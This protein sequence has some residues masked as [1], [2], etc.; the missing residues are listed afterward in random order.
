MV[1][2]EDS[3]DYPPLLGTGGNDGR[4]DF[5]N[6]FLQR[7]V[8][9]FDAETGEPAAEAAGWLDEALF[10]EVMPGIPS[11]KVGQFAQIYGG[12]IDQRF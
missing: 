12:E 6:N 3:P 1:L 5:T 10:D 7:L 2:T 4:L 11:A 8:T 9:V